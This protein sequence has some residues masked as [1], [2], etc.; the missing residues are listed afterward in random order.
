M[1]A[2]SKLLGLLVLV[3]L[4]LLFTKGRMARELIG[5]VVGVMLLAMYAALMVFSSI[6]EK[7]RG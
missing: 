6:V 7:A 2:V 4:Y 5:V 3:G 1:S